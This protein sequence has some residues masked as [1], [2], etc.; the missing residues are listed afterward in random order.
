MQKKKWRQALTIGLLVV[1]FVGPVLLAALFRW[2]GEDWQPAATTAHGILFRDPRPLPE[3]PA[4]LRGKWSLLYI[5]SG[6]C[7]E[8]C[9]QGLWQTRQVRRALGREAPRV[10]RFLVTSGPVD[11]S[12]LVADHPDLAILAGDEPDRDGL[13]TALGPFAP[14]DVF[15]A[16]PLGNVI[17]RFPAG[18]TMKDLHRDLAHLLKVSRIG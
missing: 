1:V 9:R 8:D 17:M 7:T 4:G 10:Q 2:Y 3:A 14:G 12:G 11:A 18:T 13:L 15:L 16:D 6:D 5:A